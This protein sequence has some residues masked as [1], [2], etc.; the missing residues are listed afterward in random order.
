MR[1]VF[2]MADGV[3]RIALGVTLLDLINVSQLINLHDALG[4]LSL[5]AS[6]F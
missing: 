6:V 3:T 2:F 4:R 5:L 1:S